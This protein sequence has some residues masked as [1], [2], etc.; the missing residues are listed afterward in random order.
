MYYSVD[1]VG[2]DLRMELNHNRGYFLLYFC[3][4]FLTTY[5]VMNLFI[6]VIVDKFKEEILKRQGAHN[7]S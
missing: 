7:F 5:F 1:A 3:Y 6:S 4:L 2:L